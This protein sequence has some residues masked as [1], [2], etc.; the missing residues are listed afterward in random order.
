M[1]E[2]AAT[3]TSGSNSVLNIAHRCAAAVE[4][5]QLGSGA[6]IVP[7]SPTTAALE[8]RQLGAVDVDPVVAVVPTM[9]DVPEGPE[10]V[11][12]TARRCSSRDG[13]GAP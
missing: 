9:A 7:Q 2:T 3:A 13:G 8:S 5:A 11:E 10:D 1:H 4:N 12:E 6:R